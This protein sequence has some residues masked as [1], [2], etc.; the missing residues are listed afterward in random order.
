MYILVQIVRSFDIYI[1]ENQE[2][3]ILVNMCVCANF[4]LTFRKLLLCECVCLSVCLSF[5]FKI[6]ENNS[7]DRLEKKKQS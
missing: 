7:I 2:K 4:D 3:K 1:N 5:S 6:R